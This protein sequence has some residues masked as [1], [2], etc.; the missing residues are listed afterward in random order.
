MPKPNTGHSSAICPVKGLRLT[1]SPQT[2]P[3]GMR[4]ILTQLVVVI[5]TVTVL[6]DDTWLH[7]MAG[8]AAFF[9]TMG[10]AERMLKP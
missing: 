3:Y 2:G 8:F 5:W 9:L 6:T 7:V 1:C 4:V 10:L